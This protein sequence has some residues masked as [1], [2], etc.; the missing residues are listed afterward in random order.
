MDVPTGDGRYFSGILQLVALLI[1]SGQ[2]Q[3][4]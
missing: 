4:Y 3:V 2:F 1:L